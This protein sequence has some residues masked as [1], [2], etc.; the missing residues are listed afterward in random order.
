MMLIILQASYGAQKYL[1]P[2]MFNAIEGMVLRTRN[3]KYRVLGSSGSAIAQL[4]DA[5]SRMASGITRT[6]EGHDSPK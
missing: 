5:L 3:L 6:H 2:M 4:A 1:R